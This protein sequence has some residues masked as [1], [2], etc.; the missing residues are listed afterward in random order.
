[1]EHPAL[2]WIS[3]INYLEAKDEQA[4]VNLYA[5]DLLWSIARR[6]Y[7]NDIP[8]PSEV[9]NGKNKTDRRSGKQIV[10]DL[11]DGLGGE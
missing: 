11:M 6:N 10:Q 1:M 7:Q 9:W 5:M 8:M 4:K 2:E 3:R